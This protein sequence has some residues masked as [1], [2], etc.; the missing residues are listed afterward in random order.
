MG[1]EHR[2]KALETAG[3]TLLVPVARE[4]T[5]SERKAFRLAE[6]V[7]VT[8]HLG[9]PVLPALL[10][11]YSGI[12][13]GKM[14]YPTPGQY[15]GLAKCAGEIPESDYEAL[16]Q[17]L[18]AQIGEHH[19]ELFNFDAD[20]RWCIEAKPDGRIIANHK[21]P[22][23]AYELSGALA[24]AFGPKVTADKAGGSERLP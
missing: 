12:A 11:F 16:C 22:E 21:D 1:L 13:A 15:R 23:T 9:D 7:C 4:L 8:Y 3:A 24:L 10:R 2:L 6:A 5:D 14:Q 17:S 18:E 20:N 19:P